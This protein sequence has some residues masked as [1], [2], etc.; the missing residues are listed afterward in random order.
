MSKKKYQ[1][2]LKH[3]GILQTQPRAKIA[4]FEILIEYKRKQLQVNQKLP[5]QNFV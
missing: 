3:H 5:I 1:E 4:I 2:Q